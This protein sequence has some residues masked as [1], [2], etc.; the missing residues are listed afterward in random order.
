[1]SRRILQVRT[2]GR[3][4]LAGAGLALALLLPAA[5]SG[6][7]ADEKYRQMRERNSAFNLSSSPTTVLRVNQFQCGLRNQGDTCSDVF[8]SPTGGGGFW[9]TGSANQYMFNSGI[10][11]VG[12]IPQ[13]AN[14]AW[15]GDTVGAFFMDASGLRA[16]GT[17]VTEIYN[18]LDP[19]DLANW[20]DAGAF[21][22]FPQASAWV[23]DTSLFNDVLIGRKTAS[24]QDSWVMYWDGDPGPS[25]G[26]EHPMGILV[27][28]RSLAWNYPLGNES[29]VYFIYKLTNV[30]NNPLFQRLNEARFFGGQNALPDGGWRFDSVYVAYDADPDVTADF[31]ANYATAILPFNLGISYDGTFFEPSFDYPPSLFFPPFFTN[32]PGIVGIKYLRSPV[33]P[34]TGQEVGLTSFSLHTNGAPFPDPADVRQGWRY[35][36]LN[37]DAGKGDP[38]CTFNVSEI[39]Q[40][41]SCFLSQSQ[42]DVRFFIGSGPFSLD[43]GE[44]VTV[45]VAMYAAATVATPTITRGAN[46]D[47]KPGIP[48]IRP[49]CGAEA[50][51]PIEIGAGWVRTLNCPA[52]PTEAVSQF[53]VQVVPQSLLGRGLVAQ[54]IFDNKFLLGFAPESPPFYLVPGDNQVTVV[55]EPSGSE[56]SGDPFFAAAGNPESPL[57]DP[58]YREFDVEGYRIYRGSDPSNLQLIAQFDKEG[59]VFVDNTCITDPTFVQGETCEHAGAEVP[60]NGPFIQFPPGGVVR[61][62]DGS[63]LVVKADTAFAA[64]LAAGRARPLSDTGIP[65]AFIDNAARN[66]FQYF[67]RVTAFDINSLAS[68]P[69]SLESAGPS[70]STIPRK[71]APNLQVASFE[72]FLA[73]DNGQALDPTAP[74]PSIDPNTG[75]FSGKMPPT[76]TAEGTFIPLVQRLLPK[77][78]L[79]ATIDSVVG[80]N[81]VQG[82][83]PAGES[84]LGSCWKLYMTFDRD[85]NRTRTMI[86]G[87]T[88]TWNAFGE[89]S[90][91]QFVLG[92]AAVPADAEASQ[93]FNIPAGRINFDAAVQ[94]EFLEYIRYSAFEGQGNRRQGV[95]GHPSRLVAGGSRWFSGANEATPHPTRLIRVGRLEGV[96]SVWAPIHHTP[97]TPNGSTYPTSGQMQCF[98]YGYAFL[99]RAADVEMTWNNNTATFRDVTHNVPVIFKPNVQASFG[100]LNTDANGNGMIDWNDFNYINNVSPLMEGLGF[101][102]HADDPARRITLENAPRI[103]PVSTSGLAAGTMASTGQG[104]GLYINGERYIFQLSRLPANGTKWTLRT[105]SGFVRSQDFSGAEPNSYTFTSQDRP[106]LIPGLRFVFRVNDPTQFVGDSD[107]SLIHTVP[108]P[109]YAVSQYDLSPASKQIKFVNMPPQATIRIYSMSGVLVAVVNHDDPSG[110]ASATWNVRNRTNQFVA[111]GVYFYHVSTP[112]GRSHIGKFTVVNSGFAR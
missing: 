41:R 80:D 87:W 59:T 60:L 37:I 17:P 44:S 74:V 90:E 64:E 96:D 24:Q 14:F 11:V 42:S 62:K 89:P 67:Y 86:D 22:D 29:I 10:Q 94:G 45:A 57:F 3:W 103:Q 47:N 26:R 109:Y 63:A 72:S 101:C 110:G 56:R 88:P 25:G 92:K 65:F 12:V 77:F 68:G 100:F 58:N 76:N 31:R 15:A 27:E 70:Q 28:Q 105:Y 13:G 81:F 112:D 20:P 79:T 50:L 36:S 69:P 93:Q 48:S 46:A 8:N 2:G 111:S 30:T 49:G 6:Q 83:C 5:V 73:G 53:D 1:M 4:R 33:D 104:F 95:A 78:Q 9:P 108:D 18:S 71:N 16:H 107:L 39:K 102:G 85:G 55:W 40:R 61:L 82:G 99:G 97:T 43:P 52:D 54:S 21:P 23:R 106:P 7:S 91:T 35:I 38:Q 34:A 19:A 84:A 98:G 75:I 51:R 32:A 66:G